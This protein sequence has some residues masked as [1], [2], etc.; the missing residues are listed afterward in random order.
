MYVL[1]TS[2]RPL[3]AYLHQGGFARFYTVKY[4]S[5]VQDADNMMVHLTNVAIQKFGQNYNDNHGGKWMLKNL[6]L[7]LEQTKGKS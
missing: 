7:Y 4:S 3:K 6:R 1:V 5:G 2:Y